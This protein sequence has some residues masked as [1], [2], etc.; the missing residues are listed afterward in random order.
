MER[1]LR[2]KQSDLILSGVGTI[3]LGG[4]AFVRVILSILF[5]ANYVNR[6]FDFDSF[7][8][9]LKPITLFLWVLIGFFGM[10]LYLYVGTRAVREGRT[11]K[12]QRGYLVLAAV[13]LVVNV[14]LFIANLMAFSTSQPEPLDLIGELLQGFA[15]A[16]NFGAMLYAARQTRKLS[17]N[18]EKEAVGHAN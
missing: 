13:L 6:V 10:L 18:I 1:V 9:A 16:A 14:L 5:A 2:K 15:R 4:W 8:P 7:D 3:L 11:G 12:R 17:L